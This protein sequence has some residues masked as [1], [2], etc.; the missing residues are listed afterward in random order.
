MLLLKHIHK[1]ESVFALLQSN[2]ALFG[3]AKSV[4]AI[5]GPVFHELSI[6]P[7]L[8]NRTQATAKNS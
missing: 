7:H 2:L 3:S 5:K 4:D 6:H 1:R 8:S